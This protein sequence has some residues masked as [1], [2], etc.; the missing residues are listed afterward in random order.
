MMSTGKLFQG[1]PCVGAWVSYALGTVNQNRPAYVVL[2][3][4]AGYNTTGKLVWSSGWL[5]ALHQGVAFNSKGA[6]VLDLQ[7]PRPWPEG[8]Q[9]ASLAFP[10]RQ[11]EAHLRRFP[12]A[13]ELEARL[14][15]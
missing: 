7:P 14:R 15:N 4:P 13:T 2:R 6:P 3:D 1:R 8:V 5:P 10:A 12:P 9:R 11:N